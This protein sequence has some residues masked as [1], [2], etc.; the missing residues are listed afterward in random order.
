MEKAEDSE[1]WQTIFDEYGAAKIEENPRKIK[2]VVSV[3]DYVYKMK[4]G[5]ERPIPV[6][7][8]NSF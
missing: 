7:D 8:L 4:K 5:I 3:F 1:D 2:D 6:I